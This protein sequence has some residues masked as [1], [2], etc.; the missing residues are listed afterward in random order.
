[1]NVVYS[2]SNEYSKHAGISM[3]SLFENNKDVDVLDVFIIDYGICDDNKH[4]LDAIAKKYGRKIFYRSFDQEDM[5]YTDNCYK[6]QINS[7]ARLFLAAILPES[8][9]KVIWLD[10]D[11][12]VTDSL[13]DLWNT[14]LQGKAIAA[15]QD[16]GS[17]YFW[18][19]T[20]TVD[21]YRYIC[22]GVFLADLEKWRRINVTMQFQE[23]MR[24]MNGHLEHVDQTVL[25]GVLHQDCVIVHPRYDVLTPTFV[26]PYD[27]LIAYFKLEKGYYS[28]QEIRDSIRKPAII[29]FTSSN[30]GRP[31]EKG[32]KH[33]R[34]KEYQ[35]YWKA[36]AW[37]DEPWGIFR[38]TMGRKFHRTL[39]LY[40]HVPV[41]M[42]ELFQKVKGALAGR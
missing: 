39:W 16:C 30:I 17:G 23:Y 18:K 31:W 27:N 15:V 8:V 40:Q 2:S 25:N 38:P 9:K 5:V 19:E 42:I 22:A 33:P 29:H 32:N 6:I 20:G 34:A 26:M 7:Y 24:Q 37:K 13:T 3:T 10:C 36:S 12:V 14:D 28:K 11:T 21:H 41:K 4:K 35:K 1:M